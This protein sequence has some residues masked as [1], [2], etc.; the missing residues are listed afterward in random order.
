MKTLSVE[1]AKAIDALDINSVLTCLENGA[2]PN[3]IDECG[4]TPLTDVA[5]VSHLRYDY[6]RISTEDQE[7]GMLAEDL[8]KIEIMKI[9]LKA[10]AD[11]NLYGE[12][13][14]TALDCASGQAKVQLVQFLLE[15][16][17]NPNINF[18]EDEDP[19]ILSS[20][21][22][23]AMEDA[24]LQYESKVG[25]KFEMIVYY[26]KMHGAIEYKPEQD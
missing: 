4:I 8:K 19:E 1:L 2:D 26:L 20:I 15:N 7:K 18:Y 24:F 10:G 25:D 12:G 17:A 16:G 23:T 3:R 21:L 11:I 22:H 13:G 14:Y 9:M 5:M 6:T